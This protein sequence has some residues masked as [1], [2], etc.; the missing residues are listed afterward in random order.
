[1]RH[2]WIATCLAT[3][4]FVGQAIAADRAHKADAAES[5]AGVLEKNAAAEGSKALPSASEIIT[6]SEA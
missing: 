6:K 3:I 2:I 5:K 4:L 1:M